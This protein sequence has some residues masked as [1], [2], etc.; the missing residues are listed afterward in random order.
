MQKGSQYTEAR[1][2]LRDT[3][4]LVPYYEKAADMGNENAQTTKKR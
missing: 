3:S 1:Y 4:K 2:G